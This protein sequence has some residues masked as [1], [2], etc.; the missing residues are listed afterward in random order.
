VSPGAALKPDSFLSYSPHAFPG[1][2]GV[3]GIAILLVMLFHFA[4]MKAATRFDEFFYTFTRYGWSGVDLFF[5]LSGF[6]I[7]GILVDAK[8]TE[9]YFRNFYARRALRVFPLYYVFVAALLLL[10]PLIGG[11]KVAKEALVLQQN[12]WWV[13]T[14]MVNW[15]VARTGDFWTTT[16]LGTGGFWSLSIEEQY[17]LVWPVVILL[18]PRQHLLRLCLT[19]IALATGVR[20][21]MVMLGASW[22]AIFT[23]TFARLDSIA[24]GATIAMIAR[25]PGGLSIVKHLAPAIG[26]VALIGLG[27]GE[28]LS[29]TSYR[30]GDTLTLAIQCTLFVWL[31]GAVVVGALTAAQGGFVQH[32]THAAV[33]RSLGKYS[34]A[35]YLFHGHFNRLSERL[36]LNPYGSVTVGGSVLPVQI[37]YIVV[38]ISMSFAAAYLSWHLLEKQ[39]LKLKKLFPRQARRD[40]RQTAGALQPAS[41]ALESAVPPF[42]APERTGGLPRDNT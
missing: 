7:T 6:L 15:L 14:H 12:Q 27:M 42:I 13:W 4:S 2:D 9:H 23:V 3:R 8:G 32:V 22:A 29:R 1:L 21:A 25:S 20:F 40:V 41:A 35:L 16:P 5:V 34:F 37:L 39:F 33:L 10:Y 11:E 26:T 18:V 24:M 28:I 36:G 38:S 19:L 17:Y 30:P 31:W